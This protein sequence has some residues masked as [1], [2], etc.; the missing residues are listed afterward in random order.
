MGTDQFR[1]QQ[2]KELSTAKRKR[3]N[4]QKRR[5]LLH[6]LENICQIFDCQ[7]T[8]MT[9]RYK[10]NKLVENVQIIQPIFI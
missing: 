10:L 3:K 9:N 6:I 5:Y 7:S 4:K 8:S 1:L 2:T